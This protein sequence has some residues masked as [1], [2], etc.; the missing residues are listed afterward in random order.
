MRGDQAPFGNKKHSKVV[1]EN[2]EFDINSPNGIL[3][4]F[5]WPV[6]RLKLSVAI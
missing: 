5:F 2:L 3:E 6:K 4:N 1:P